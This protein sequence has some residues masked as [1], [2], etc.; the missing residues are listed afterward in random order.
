MN[1]PKD[2]GGRDEELLLGSVQVQTASLLLVDPGH[3]PAD[4][5][6]RLLTPDADGHTPGMVL[7]LA[8]DGMYDVVSA[9]GVIGVVDPTA[10]RTSRSPSS[11][12]P[13]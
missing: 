13:T 2:D 6:A 1:Q 12:G 9:P 3:L 4:V 5:V 11:S 8:G 7:G 10:T